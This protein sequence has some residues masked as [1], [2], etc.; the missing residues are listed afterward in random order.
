L[1]QDRS[2]PFYLNLWYTGDRDG[3]T[4]APSNTIVRSRGMSLTL[5]NGT[6]IED[7]GGQYYVN[8]L[9]AGRPEMARIL[10]AQIKKMSWVSPSEFVDVRL[11]LTRDLLG[12]LP[13][14]ITTPQYSVGGS[15][16]LES[17]IRAARKVTRRTRVLSL[18]QS[19][20]GDTMT[21]ENVSGGGLTPY[22]DPRPWA[23]HA[24]SPY[25][26]WERAGRDW[27]RACDLS[28]EGIERALKR[29]GART[30]AAL[31]VEPVMTSAGAVPISRP[32]ARGLRALCDRHGIKLVADEVVTGFGRTGRWFGSESVGLVPDAMILAKG[33]TGGYAPLGAA[34]FERSWGEELRRS[35]L[36]HGLTFAG[37]PLG[38]IAA[39]A[40]IRILRRERLIDRAARLGRHLRAGLET[41]RDR[42]PG[43]V[44]D[45]RGH[46]LLLALQIEAR[47]G[48]SAE[49]RVRRIITAARAARIH[50]LPTGDRTG[51]LFTPPFIVT[52]AR[53]DRLIE[54]LDRTIKKV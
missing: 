43:A 3:R 37:H 9:G 44:A 25:D 8:N 10:A 47:R 17:A 14:R 51:I 18:D 13:R 40:T 33:I 2:R 4:P 22:A 11:G 20:H 53:I 27:P 41:L 1:R 46:G 15:D 23:V 34:V 42:H 35:G 54:F 24:P 28:L 39:R 30:F 36:N 32:L 49:E 21:V 5:Q 16:A 26:C 45:V 31:V 50:L 29:H 38:C 7:W 12:I 48:A 52:A 19:Y 6:I